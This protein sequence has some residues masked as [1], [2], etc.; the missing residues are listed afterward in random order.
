MKRNILVLLTIAAFSTANAQQLQTSSLYDMQGAFFNPSMAGTGNN[1]IG[2]SYRSQWSGIEGSPSTA[3]L[4]GSFAIPKHELGLSA[5]LYSDKTGP[6]SRKGAQVAFAKHIIFADKSKLSLGIEARFLQ[7]AIDQAKLTTILGN[8]PVLGG[9]ANNTKFDAGFGI[10]YT[11]DRFQ[12]GAA[13]S[14]LLQSNMDFYS[15][16]LTRTEQARLYRHF[17]FNGSYRFDVDANTTIT[18][19]FLLTYLPN[20]PV[21]FQGVA[22]IEYKKLVWFGFGYRVQQGP[23]FSGGLHIND[24]LSI[25][26]SFDIY[27][28]PVNLFDNKSNAN[29][30]LIRYNFPTAK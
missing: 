15:G 28:R 24:N 13:V 21:E 5:Y 29:E 18:P 27:N 1:M 6:T 22:K 10:S 8:D 16:N 3:T 26:Y 14:Q 19:N 20:A 25:G 30:F 17:F 23:M 9:S 4:F 2:F 12:L 11:N 7:F